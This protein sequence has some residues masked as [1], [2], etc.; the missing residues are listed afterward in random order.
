MKEI[1]AWVIC[2]G[3]GLIV[4]VSLTWAAFTFDAHDLGKDKKVDCYDKNGNKIIGQTCIN[5]AM[6]ELEISIF[7]MT[8]SF[9]AGFFVFLVSFIILMPMRQAGL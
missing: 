5:K 6:S 3:L 9:L 8:N 4:F 2:W 1:Y 7:I